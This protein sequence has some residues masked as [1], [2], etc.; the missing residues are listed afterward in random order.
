MRVDGRRIPARVV[1]GSGASVGDVEEAALGTT[2]EVNRDAVIV[3]DTVVVR[4]VDCAKAGIQ[5]R[6]RSTRGFS[7]QIAG[8]HVNV[9]AIRNLAGGIAKPNEVSSMSSAVEHGC[10]YVVA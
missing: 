4:I 8:Q 5:P 6:R 7:N 9:N 3:S 2:S 10:H 1:I